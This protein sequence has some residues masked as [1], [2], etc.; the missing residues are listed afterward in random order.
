MDVGNA[1]ALGVILGS[2]AHQDLRFAS[3]IISNL[4]VS[5]AQAAPPISTGCASCLARCRRLRKKVKAAAKISRR[6]LSCRPV[7]AVAGA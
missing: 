6:K 4:H 5:P 7:P 1:Q 3:V 2:A